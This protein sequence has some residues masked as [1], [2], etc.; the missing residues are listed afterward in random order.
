MAVALGLSPCRPYTTPT[1]NMISAPGRHMPARAAIAPV[2]P[3]S[4][5]P[6]STDMFVAF[7]PGSVWL[8][9]S[10]STNWSSSSQPCL[11][12]RLA[13]RYGTTVPK[14][15]DPS[16]R[17]APKI[18]RMVAPPADAPDCCALTLGSTAPAPE[19]SFMA[20]GFVA[21]Q[22]INHSRLGGSER[23]PVLR[24]VLQRDE[25]LLAALFGLVVNFLFAFKLALV[26]KLSHQGHV[27]SAGPPQRHVGLCHDSFAEIQLPQF[28]Q[29]LFDDG[30]VHQAHFCRLGS[31]QL[32]QRWKHPA[33][34]GHRLG[35]VFMK[36]A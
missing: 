15:V 33:E 17:K 8:M 28:Q 5:C 9:E 30:V 27:F 3:R 11:V 18:S 24:R 35:T 23:N 16:N 26:G 10:N 2:T 12:T 29:H 31:L 20:L 19:V 1:A 22:T 7:R 32:R 25:K 4:R 36:L 6:T 21:V 34:G 14:L 13:R